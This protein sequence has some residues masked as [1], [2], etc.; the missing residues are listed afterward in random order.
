MLY[1]NGYNLSTVVEDLLTCS[2]VLLFEYKNHYFLGTVA[3]VQA[4]Y[5]YFVQ[6][7]LAT[8]EIIKYN[9][10]LEE[11]D[12]LFPISVFADAASVLGRLPRIDLLQQSKEGLVTTYNMDRSYLDGF[13]LMEVPSTNKARLS[14]VNFTMEE[15]G[16]WSPQ[17]QELRVI[18][19]S[20][21]LE[22]LPCY[23]AR[24]CS[25]MTFYGGPHPLHSTNFE[26]T[27]EIFRRSK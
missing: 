7:I 12:K 3:T 8:S 27:E 11:L 13:V 4:S 10:S 25:L 15:L 17:T 22:W 9:F 18:V 6:P 20:G 1:P 24:K 19:D 16:F 23:S 14:N 21:L 5:T 2:N 26:I